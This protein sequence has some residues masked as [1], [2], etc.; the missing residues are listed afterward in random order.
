[1][2]SAPPGPKKKIK[3]SDVIR[4]FVLLIIAVLLLVLAFRGISF[5]LII[6]QILKAKF[7][8]VFLSFLISAVAHVSRAIR[9]NL[10]MEP[11]GYYPP[12][13][14]T[15][16]AVMTG[17]LGNLA[18][19]RLGEVTRCGSLT[20][21]DSIPFNKLLG[22]VITERI[23]DVLSLLICLLIVM[24][25]EFNRLGNFLRDN[26]IKP[27]VHKFQVIASPLLISI[28]III[29]LAFIFFIVRYFKK[30]KENRFS[31]LIRGVTEGIM[32]VRALKRPWLFIFHSV[33]IWFL[34]FLSVYVAFFAL[35]STENLGAGAALF[36][37]VA[38]GVAMSAPVQ[39]GIGAY[40]LLVSQGLLLYGLTQE[41]GLAFATL[42]HSLQIIL[43][44]LLGS[45]SFF[46]L[47]SGGQSKEN[48]QINAA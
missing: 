12:L 45:L 37:L 29:L 14:R 23:I 41:E 20:K 11:L 27:V 28:A 35:P 38:A 46:L 24:V 1:L 47:F 25:I 39:G 17:Y 22:T 6:N 9:W 19:P 15:F 48:S 4:F 40:H 5:R 34:Y 42:L 7:F 43:S 10:L 18:F 44:V 21:S 16:Y 13:R 31:N 36:L 2:I 3:L 30:R 32:S 33:V 26:I 8:W